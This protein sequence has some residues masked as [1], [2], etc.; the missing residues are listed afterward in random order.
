MGD[1][2]FSEAPHQP[3][4][5]HDL[6]LPEV[7]EPTRPRTRGDCVDGP[8]PCPWVSCV[9][10]LL[11]EVTEQGSLKLNLGAGQRPRWS[12]RSISVRGRNADAIDVAVDALVRMQHSCSLDVAD[13]G[14]HTLEEVGERLGVVRER[15][16]QVQALAMVRARTHEGYQT[17]R[18]RHDASMVQVPENARAGGKGAEA[19]VRKKVRSK[20][21]T[22]TKT[23]TRG[24][25][26]H[27]M[28][29][30]RK[31]GWALHFS[32]DFSGEAVL[33]NEKSK[34]QHRFPADL[35]AQAAWKEAK[36]TPV[37]SAPSEKPKRGRRAGKEE[38]GQG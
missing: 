23:K 37:E 31:N 27:D 24:Y 36:P 11:T 8:R 28:R 14:E 3:V 20:K 32:D 18:A 21:S 5:G 26:M 17:L 29:T 7:E 22:K 15:V 6:D 35:I 12:S 38:D 34:E 19:P 30:M 33:E 1:D 25:Q 10:H 2:M 4:N 16:R 9:H 13:D